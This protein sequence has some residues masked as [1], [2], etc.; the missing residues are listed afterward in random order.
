MRGLRDMERVIGSTDLQI[1]GKSVW[2]YVVATQ[3]ELDLPLTKQLKVTLTAHPGCFQARTDDANTN[4]PMCGNHQ[5]SDDSSLSHRDMRT[6]LAHSNEAIR[7][8]YL[9]KCLPI[10]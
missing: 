3:L 8:K 4:F 2:Q 9:D 7:F 1:D 10:N 6:G 5:R